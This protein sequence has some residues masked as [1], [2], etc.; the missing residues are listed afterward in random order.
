ML[1]KIWST[2]AVGSQSQEMAHCALPLLQTDD[3]QLLQL[4]TE[5]TDQ[6]ETE[7][8]NT[9]RDPDDYSEQQ[10]VCNLATQLDQ[11]LLR[12]QRLALQ[13]AVL[14]GSSLIE[15]FRNEVKQQ[16]SPVARDRQ[17]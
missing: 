13:K 11:R 3:T 2:C 17:A 4:T 10:R 6:L 15:E 14:Y 12:T 9:S 8:I 16:A 5:P 1:R 7:I